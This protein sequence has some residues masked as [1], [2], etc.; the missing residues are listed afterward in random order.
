[1]MKI[2][3][4]KDILSLKREFVNSS[5]RPVEIE[6]IIIAKY[7][8]IDIKQINSTHYRMSI[9]VNESIV[10]EIVCKDVTYFDGLLRDA[11][12]NDILDVGSSS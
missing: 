5:L 3:K 12:L 11:K 1:M 4:N 10:Y 9:F 8:S 7:D 6:S 2:I